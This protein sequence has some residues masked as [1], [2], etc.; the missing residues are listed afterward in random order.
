MSAREQKTVRLRSTEMRALSLRSAN[1]GNILCLMMFTIIT[2]QLMSFKEAV[3]CGMG[4]YNVDGVCCYPCHAGYKVNGTCSIMTGTTCVPCDPGTYTAHQNGLKKCFQC[5]GCDS[6]SGF[7]TKW[8]RSST[9]N[10]LCG[11]SPGY[12]CTNIKDDDCERCMAHRVCTPG[13]YIKSTGTERNNNICEECQAGAFS[14][15]G[16]LT[17]CLP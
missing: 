9:L 7:R 6:E 3:Q 10:T 17:Q 4:Q 1:T 11:C 2:T 8:E 14:P 12:F 5:K 13:Q 16:T 15:N